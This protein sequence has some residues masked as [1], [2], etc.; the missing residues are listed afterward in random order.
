[1]GFM[2]RGC[3]ILRNYSVNYRVTGV[4]WQCLKNMFGLNQRI[5]GM[6]FDFDATLTIMNGFN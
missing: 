1:M 6:F 2:G 4:P 3:F 5:K